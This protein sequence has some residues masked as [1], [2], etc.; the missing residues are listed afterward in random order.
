[1]EEGQITAEEAA[2][3]RG[4]HWLY[5]S[6]GHQPSVKVDLFQRRLAPG[7]ALLLCSDGLSGMVSDEDAWRVWR[8]SNSPQEACDW[9]VEAANQAGGEDN[10]TVVIIQVSS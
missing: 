3:H 1:V 9:L 5:R 7:E 6:I 2:N 8:T 10:I 4:K